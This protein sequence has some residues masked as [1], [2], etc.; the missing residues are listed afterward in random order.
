MESVSFN[1]QFYQDLHV[2]SPTLFEEALW[3]FFYSFYYPLLY[4]HFS[5]TIAPSLL[6][7]Q[8]ICV[9]IPIPYVPSKQFISLKPFL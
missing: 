1:T 3:A 6:K 2:L 4:E 7:V 8:I 5:F 9:F